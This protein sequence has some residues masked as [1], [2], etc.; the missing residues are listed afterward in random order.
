MTPKPKQR[1]R[2]PYSRI[3]WLYLYMIGAT[4]VGL[5]LLLANLFPGRPL[6]YDLILALA[7][8]VLGTHALR[9]LLLGPHRKGMKLARRGQRKEA[10]A[11]FEQSYRFMARRPWIDTLRWLLLMSPSSISYRE[12]A[13]YNIASCHL[14][15]GSRANARQYFEKVKTEFPHGLL[16]PMAARQ[17]EGLK[18]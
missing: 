17:L 4:L 18:K 7:I 13:L 8:Y 14:K 9:L 12:I 10:I 2:R 1:A 11:A 15:S 16:A 3:S 6:V 5:V